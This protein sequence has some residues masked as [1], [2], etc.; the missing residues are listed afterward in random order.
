MGT[1]EGISL[2]H[3]L[4]DSLC[5]QLPILLLKPIY[6]HG[7]NAFVWPNI[8][9]GFI[10]ATLIWLL[11]NSTY[12]TIHLGHPCELLGMSQVTPKQVLRIP[13]LLQKKGSVQFSKWT[14]WLLYETVTQTFLQ[15]L[16]WNLVLKPYFFTRILKQNRVHTVETLWFTISEEMSN[17]NSSREDHSCNF[18]HSNECEHY[19][20]WGCL[21]WCAAHLSWG[22]QRKNYKGSWYS[23]L[24]FFTTMLLY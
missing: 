24:Y 13:T 16:L 22:P 14:L 9:V 1:E 15:E 5:K 23:V 17:T 10:S 21:C 8:W 19:N 7:L 3:Q 6:H 2:M 4:M 12:W 11:K 20:L 18:C